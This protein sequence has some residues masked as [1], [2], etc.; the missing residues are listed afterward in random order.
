MTP[1]IPITK[2][3][4]VRICK[5]S[6]RTVNKWIENQSIPMPTPIAGSRKLYWHPDVF[7]RWLE[8]E[9]GNSTTDEASAQFPQ[10]VRGRPRNKLPTKFQ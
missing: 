2:E 7:Y 1:I 6:L 5:V 3:D 9:L 8:K 10:R 4:A